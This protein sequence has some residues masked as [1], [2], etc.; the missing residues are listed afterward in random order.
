MFLQ[1]VVQLGMQCRS[2]VLS[3]DGPGV[4]FRAV[5][6]DPD[7]LPVLTSD[8]V[9]YLLA[10]FASF[11]KVETANVK[12]YAH[13]KALLALQDRADMLTEQFGNLSVSS[14]KE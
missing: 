5:V 7:T 12:G 2:R 11:M 10:Y 1:C 6:L 4:P 9:D 3:L 8:D 13:K 14:R